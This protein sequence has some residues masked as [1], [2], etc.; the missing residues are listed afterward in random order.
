MSP[1]SARAAGPGKAAPRR[2]AFL[3]VPNGAHMADWTPK[4]EGGAFELPPILE[5]LAPFRDD[6]LVL[7]GLAQDNAHAK[8]DGGG[9]HARSLACFLTGIHP[10]KTDGAN[11]RVGISV[12]QVA[13]RTLGAK[14][15]LPSLDLGCDRGRQPGNG[16]PGYHCD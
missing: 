10:K 14:T 13:A 8:G 6:L 11:I 9:D 12:D 7:T 5:P 2:M 16:D 4:N 1:A 3:Y 15:R